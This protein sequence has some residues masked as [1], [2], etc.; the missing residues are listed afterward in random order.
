MLPTLDFFSLRISLFLSEP[1][2]STA[3]FS[4]LHENF[5][6]AATF[7]LEFR[8]YRKLKSPDND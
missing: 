3:L 2:E 4:A 7:G 1:A 8:A 5:I 6:V